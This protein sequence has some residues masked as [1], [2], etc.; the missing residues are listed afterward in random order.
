MPAKEALLDDGTH[1]LVVP[2]VRGT[3]DDGKAVVAAR[4][5]HT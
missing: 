1:A 2:P 3:V 5:E 4:P